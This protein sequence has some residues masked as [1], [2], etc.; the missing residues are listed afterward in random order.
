MPRHVL[1]IHPELPQRRERLQTG[2]KALEQRESLTSCESNDWCAAHQA[3]GL[4]WLIRR[5][6]GGDYN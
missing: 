1:L 6:R 5:Y 4:I 3:E 2:W